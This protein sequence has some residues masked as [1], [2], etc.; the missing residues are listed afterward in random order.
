MVAAVAQARWRLLAYC[1]MP[2][3]YHLLLKTT[4][5]G[6]SDGMQ[7]LNGTYAARYNTA[8]SRTGHV[9][10]GRF[11]AELIRRDAHLLQALRYIA[12][13]PVRAGITPTAEE[14]VWSSHRAT[15]GLQRPP[16]WLA[17]SDVHALFAANAA[18][19]VEFIARGV[20]AGRP[21]LGALVTSASAS[22]MM[23]ARHEY[24]YTQAQIATHLGIS[25]PTVSRILRQ[26]RDRE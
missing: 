6:L 25:Q 11:H 16:S 2:N 10:Q 15:A 8:H 5:P 7:Y 1:L 4:Q 26:A 13:N 12:L 22:Q 23:T 18:H 20:E 14:W 9:F 3:H 17:V 19:Y 24:G 21:N